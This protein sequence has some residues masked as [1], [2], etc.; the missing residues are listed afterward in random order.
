MVQGVQAKL[1]GMV[2]RLH[3]GRETQKKVPNRSY[4]CTTAFIF[5]TDVITFVSK[6]FLYMH[7][8]VHFL[9]LAPYRSVS[10]APPVVAY[11]AYV[12]FI[13]PPPPP[14]KAYGS[15]CLLV[16]LVAASPPDLGNRLQAAID[17]LL[18]TALRKN[19]FK[20]L[21]VIKLHNSLPAR[22]CWSS[23][24]EDGHCA[25]LCS[26]VKRCRFSIGPCNYR[27]LC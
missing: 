15:W 18:T 13:R 1:N 16:A 27:V 24:A 19:L 11:I 10:L 14:P 4:T 3:T 9:A 8:G 7:H 12:A 25:E 5:C 22:T 23:I 17:N 20:S 26:I 21:Q 6:P 2:P